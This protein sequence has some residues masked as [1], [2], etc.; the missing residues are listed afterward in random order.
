FSNETQLTVLEVVERVLKLMDS[1]LEPEVRNEAVN[2]IRQQYLNA[3]KARK[4]LG[5]SPL[6][7]LDDGLRATIDWYKEFLGAGK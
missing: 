1:K 6:F 2:E 3:E 7:N 4:V 5:W